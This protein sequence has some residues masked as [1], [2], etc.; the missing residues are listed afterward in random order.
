MWTSP[1]P[2][3]WSTSARSRYRA[4]EGGRADGARDRGAT[5]RAAEGRRAGGGP[6]GRDHGGQAHRRAD[7]ALPPAA[8]DAPGRRALRR[9]RESRD[10]GLRRDHRA[11]GRRD[12]GARGRDGRGADR[13]RHGQGRRLWDGDRRGASAGEGEGVKAAVVTVSDGVSEGTREDESG[14]LLASLLTEDG[15]EVERRVV[16]DD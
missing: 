7:P 15:Y 12:G 5:R 14:D 6:P 10:R 8:A 2:S 1:A 13:L 9:R 3:G 16:S 11:D 4:G